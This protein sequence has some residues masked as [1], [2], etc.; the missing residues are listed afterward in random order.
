[1][2][3]ADQ[4]SESIRVAGNKLQ[5]Q[6]QEGLTRIATAQASTDAANQIQATL[7]KLLPHEA[8]MRGLNE[9]NMARITAKFEDIEAT[10]AAATAIDP[11]QQRVQ[12]G[13]DW[14]AGKL[15]QP[16]A[17]WDASPW[18][19]GAR[20]PD[21]PGRDGAAPRQEE[22]SPLQRKGPGGEQASRDDEQ[23]AIHSLA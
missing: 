23:G 18:G 12:A 20:R 15:G 21:G 8:N 3:E 9:Q 16:S 2:A 14:Q 11:M 22:L 13:L 17:G 10:R 19:S 7:A 6:M 5:E 1:M 4:M